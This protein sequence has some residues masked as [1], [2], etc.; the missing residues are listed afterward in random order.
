[1]GFLE[2]R[3]EYKSRVQKKTKEK[4]GLVTFGSALSAFLTEQSDENLEKL[5]NVSEKTFPPE[6]PTPKEICGFYRNILTTP[7]WDEDLLFSMQT[8]LDLGD[9]RRTIY[10]NQNNLNKTIETYHHAAHDQFNYENKVMPERNEFRKNQHKVNLEKLAHAVKQNRPLAQTHL[11]VLTNAYKML[12][13]HSLEKPDLMISRYKEAEI[14][15]QLHTT[16][17]IEQLRNQAIYRM[18]H[19]RIIQ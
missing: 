6:S 17:R 3:E 7:F 12:M 15:R 18:K 8:S 19:E 11:V 16:K 4:L 9:T 14:W 2:N 5:V 10:L 1:M 13:T